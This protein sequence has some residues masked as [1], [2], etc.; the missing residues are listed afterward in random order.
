[1]NDIQDI[2]IISQ[3]PE[4]G[5]VAAALT[6]ESIR[7]RRVDSY[8]LVVQ[9]LGQDPQCICAIDAD[10]PRK[11]LL[12]IYELAGQHQSR[13]VLV[14]VESLQRARGNYPSG[15]VLCLKG[16]TGIESVLRIKAALVVAGPDVTN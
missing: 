13:P 10:V 8:E 15:V 5:R 4:M 1:L 6:A 9:L 2:V 14:L 12:R 7:A 16:R 3:N 11:L